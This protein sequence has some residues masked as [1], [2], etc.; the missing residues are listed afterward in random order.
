MVTQDA[1]FATTTRLG[2]DFGWRVAINIINGGN[3][4]TLKSFERSC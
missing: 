1:S 3:E 4:G 2:E